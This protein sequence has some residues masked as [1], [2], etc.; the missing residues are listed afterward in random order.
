MEHPRD[1]AAWGLSEM[2]EFVAEHQLIRATMD[3]CMLGLKSKDG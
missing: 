3:Q 2:D 1:S